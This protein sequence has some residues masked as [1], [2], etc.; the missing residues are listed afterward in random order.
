[1]SMH[2]PSMQS[3]STTPTY[4]GQGATVPGYATQTATHTPTM[5]APMATASHEVRGRTSDSFRRE[6]HAKETKGSLKTSEL[7]LA[8][9]GIAA[10][11]ALYN[12]TDDESLDLWRTC[13]LCTA[14]G[15]AYI[16]SRGFAKSG[17]RTERWSSRDDG[18]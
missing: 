5:H 8:L 13:L 7:W 9:A 14:I 18:F 10:L 1:M 2:D 12:I 17:S 16:V 4:G 3:T 6:H 15:V 11:I